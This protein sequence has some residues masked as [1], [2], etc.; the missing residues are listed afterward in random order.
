T[1]GLFEPHIGKLCEM[2]HNKGGLVFGDGAN[3]N[4]LLGKTRPGDAGFDAMQLNLHKT[5]TTPHGGGGPGCGPVAY[6]KILADYAPLPIVLRDEQG[7]YSLSH[8]NRPKSI[9]RVRSFQGNFGMAVR[10]YAYLRE[11]G[12]EG[13]SK[14]SELAVLNANYLRVRLGQ[15]WQ[16]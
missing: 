16:V 2:I 1:V 4:A 3:L 13:L 7:R 9:G 14:V 12:A 8:S 10:A 11:L 6:K 5:F 15:T